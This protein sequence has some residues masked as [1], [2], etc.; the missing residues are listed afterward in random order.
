MRSACI[1][2]ALALAIGCSDSNPSTTNPSTTNPS[3]NHPSNPVAQTV[4]GP[5]TNP[6]NC[7][8][9]LP[10]CDRRDGIVAAARSDVDRAT[11]D[12]VVDSATIG[13]VVAMG[14]VLAK[15]G[16]A[17]TVMNRPFRGARM[18]CLA[19][20][21]MALASAA[22]HDPSRA[23]AIAAQLEA[24]VEH[25]VAKPA[26]APFADEPAS[27]LYRG[28]LGMMLVALH[29]VAT[30]ALEWT[31]LMDELAEKLARDLER[32]W[33]PS[34]HD[35]I[36]PCDHAPAAAFLRLHGSREAADALVEKLRAALGAGFPTRVDRRGKVLDGTLRSTALAFTASY[37]L[38]A[39]PE[40]ARAFA[41]KLVERCD[42]VPIA[43]CR[44]GISR[45]D[46]ASGPIVA[47]YSVGATA[48][49]IVA[50]RALADQAWNAALVR[51]AALVGS[52]FD[53][54]TA[55]LETAL[56]RWGSIAR[57]W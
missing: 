45:A 32:G 48:L 47:G 39:E 23:A 34:Y 51:T 18:L 56:L 43:A 27:V 26:K 55:S 9:Q 35:G 46:A 14:D 50:T 17:A 5:D 24:L 10:G 1:T 42:R 40:L 19:A 13:A 3:T 31:T 37:L 2:L 28:L 30:P 36:W 21:S 11:I 15:H 7:F 52:D 20:A 29:R 25:A 41:E 57:S 16:C 53:P 4:R 12:A 8:D 6:I 33:L 22:L 54:R 49:A 38:P 44:E